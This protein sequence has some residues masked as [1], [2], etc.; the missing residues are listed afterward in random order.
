MNGLVGTGGRDGESRPEP[1]VDKPTHPVPEATVP[2]AKNRRGGA[3]E[4]DT[5]FA[6]SVRAARRDDDKS[7]VWRSAPSDFEGNWNVPPRGLRRERCRMAGA[8]M[9]KRDGS[10][11]PR[12]AVRNRSRAE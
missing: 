1:E 6:K 5:L 7:A 3:P 10:N 8:R 4:G 2:S 12:I 11:G 9:P